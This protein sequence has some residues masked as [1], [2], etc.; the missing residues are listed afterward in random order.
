MYKRQ[1]FLG[2]FVLDEPLHA[3]ILTAAALI[4]SAVVAIQYARYR[5]LREIDPAGLR[6]AS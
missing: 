2:W 4:V 6:K 3:R 1:V 5:A